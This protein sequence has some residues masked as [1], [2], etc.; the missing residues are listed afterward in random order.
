MPNSEDD[1]TLLPS[2]PRFS[3]VARPTILQQSSNPSIAANLTLEGVAGGGGIGLG[4]YGENITIDTTGIEVDAA[5]GIEVSGD[6]N[7]TYASGDEVFI[8]VW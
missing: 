2:T 5:R 7:G 1:A 4:M 3:Y 6:G 8:T